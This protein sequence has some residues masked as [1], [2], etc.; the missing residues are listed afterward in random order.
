MKQLAKQIATILIM[1][2]FMTY[3]S[4]LVISVH[5]CCHAHHHS[6]NDHSHC[7]ENTYFFKITD[8]FDSSDTQHVD[9]AETFIT[10]PSA[11]VFVA[12]C[13]DIHIVNII[14]H[15]DHFPP[16][17]LLENISITNFI[18]NHRL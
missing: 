17:L 12:F 8:N 13:Q 1:T 2:V 10:L 11:E 15:S 9:N 16:P 4:G 5:H 14:R 3:A 7:H 6:A 18:S